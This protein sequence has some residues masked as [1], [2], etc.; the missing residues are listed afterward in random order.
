MVFAFRVK[1][2][3]VLKIFSIW[4]CRP[5]FH[6]SFLSRYSCWKKQMWCIAS[7]SPCAGASICA[8]P[9][10]LDWGMNEGI[11]AKMDLLLHVIHFRACTCRKG[12]R[13]RGRN[14]PPR[15]MRKQDCFICWQN[16]FVLSG[17]G[18]TAWL[19]KQAEIFSF[20][21]VKI[22]RSPILWGL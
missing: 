9:G 20:P 10:K 16:W 7:A 6:E 21:R 12:G 14:E 17:S 19:W 1:W 2:G 22:L 4:K 5:S 3:A 8:A 11:K 15:G 13:Q 18:T